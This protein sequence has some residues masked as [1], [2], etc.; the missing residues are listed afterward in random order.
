M[1]LGRIAVALWPGICTKHHWH[2]H[3]VSAHG[4][5]QR[6]ALRVARRWHLL[7]IGVEIGCVL[8]GKYRRF[9]WRHLADRM[10][11]LGQ[12]VLIR[13]R[14]SR[15]TRTGPERALAGKAMTLITTDLNIEL[16]AIAALPARD[17]CWAEVAPA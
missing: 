10:T 4:V 7:Q 5:E 8:I 2:L 12:E 3:K 15:D 13:K 1:V 9:V 11:K 14:G 16:L 6:N 17:A